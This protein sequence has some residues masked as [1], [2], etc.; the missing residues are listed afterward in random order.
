[1]QFLY[2]TFIIGLVVMSLADAKIN[3]ITQDGEVVDTFQDRQTLYCTGP[4]SKLEG[5]IVLAEPP[6]ACT[7]VEEPT[8][9]TN[10]TLF[11]FVLI[12]GSGSCTLMTKMQNVATAGFNVAVLYDRNTLLRIIPPPHGP[13]FGI[14]CVF[15]SYDD[16]VKIQKYYTYNNKSLD[17]YILMIIPNYNISYYMMLFAVVIGVCFVVMV[18]FM[19]CLLIKCV[20][21]RRRNRRNRLSTRQIKQIPTFKFAKGDQFD[22]CAICLEDY[23]EGD[24]LR[25]LPCS[26]AYHARCVDPWLMNNR[27]N[28]PLCKRKVTTFGQSSSES[29][30]DSE[31]TSPAENTP[32]MNSPTNRSRTW[33]TFSESATNQANDESNDD[34]LTQ[35]HSSHQGQ[36]SGYSY[37]QDVTDDLCDFSND[38][39]SDH[40][41]S[42]SCSVN[43]DEQEALLP[44][45]DS[46][47]SDHVCKMPHR[48]TAEPK[49]ASAADTKPGLIV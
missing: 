36:T 4:D 39:Q 16:W 47:S 12:N 8:F 43:C 35:P 2:H 44:S 5:I 3:V 32:L 21:E 41:P 18:L 49:G 19:I 34:G 10:F 42:S 46:D 23:N 27:R 25:I 17:N 40:L 13:V 6:D 20:Q 14:P 15:I 1:M 29:D 9:L 37:S 45:S 22:V 33:G 11:K 31:L 30:T 38:D 7:T 24:K 26:H 48:Q 28:C